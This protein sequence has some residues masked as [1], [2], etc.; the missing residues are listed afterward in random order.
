MANVVLHTLRESIVEQTYI[1]H[2]FQNPPD[3]CCRRRSF[4]H[5]PSVTYCEQHFDQDMLLHVAL[6]IVILKK[7]CLLQRYVSHGK[8]HKISTWKCHSVSL[9][10]KYDPPG[11]CFQ[12]IKAAP[13]VRSREIH[14]P[15]IL[16]S[17]ELQK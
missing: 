6:I 7:I 16:A 15:S 1:L 17:P 11:F 14:H 3:G 12:C 4:Q 5:L 10:I 9:K 8:V 13:K 2:F